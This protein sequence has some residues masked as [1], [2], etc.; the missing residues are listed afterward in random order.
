MT[1]NRFTVFIIDDDAMTRSLL[2]LLV[3]GGRFEVIGSSGSAVGGLANVLQL[4][5]DIVCLDIQMPD[6][7][8][9]DVLDSLTLQ[10]PDTAVLMVTASDD[11]PTVLAARARGA[12]GFVAKPFD[13][14]T[15]LASLGS[16]ADLLAG[17]PGS[18]AP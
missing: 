12:R 6:G 15:V 18:A 5:P 11:A 14:G 17:R 9:L 13:R 8:G 3:H 16:A 7:D 10:L 4:K 2:K 1:E